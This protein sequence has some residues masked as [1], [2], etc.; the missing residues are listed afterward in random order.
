MQIRVVAIEAKKPDD[1][2][3]IGACKLL[4]MNF[5]QTTANVICDAVK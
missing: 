3:E 2:I 1:S 4:P 5:E